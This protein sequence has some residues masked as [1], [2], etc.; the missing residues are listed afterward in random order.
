MKVYKGF[1]PS[2]ILWGIALILDGLVLLL[3][4]GK[5]KPELF[6]SM[7]RWSLNR[8]FKDHKNWKSAEEW[9]ATT[10]EQNLKRRKQQIKLR[11]PLIY[12][13]PVWW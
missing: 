13:Q 2:N 9:K 4:L 7:V 8:R 5:V 1:K 12:R 10:F 6:S 11:V 3:S